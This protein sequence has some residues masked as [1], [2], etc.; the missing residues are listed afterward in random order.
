MYW[1]PNFL[2]AE[3]SKSTNVMVICCTQKNPESSNAKEAH[4]NKVAAA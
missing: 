4:E 3:I 1:Q 2:S